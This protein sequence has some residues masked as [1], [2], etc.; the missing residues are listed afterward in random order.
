MYLGDD[1]GLLPNACSDIATIL[2]NTNTKAIIWNKPDYN[3][4][5]NK[6]TPNELNI[7]LNYDLIEMDSKILL[8]AVANG[9]TSYGRL[10]VIYSGFVSVDKI[11]QIKNKTGHFFHSITPDVYSGIVLAEILPNYLYSF[12]PFSINGGS[13]HSTG[14]AT[15]TNDD[16]GK[17]FFSE[18]RL[19]INAQIPIIR[20][21]IQTHVAEAFLKAQKVNLLQQYKLNFQRV[22][23]NI[24]NEL[25]HLSD[26][27]RS[28][29]LH[30][31]MGMNIDTSLRKKIENELQNENIEQRSFVNSPQSENK[32]INIESGHLSLNAA[33]FSIQNSYDACIFIGNLLGQYKMPEVTLKANTLSYAFSIVRR[34]MAIYL[35]KY[36]LPF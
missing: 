16:R 4:P 10:P 13:G 18:S 29:G 8:K 15:M 3:W 28:T 5:T 25:K 20:G 12:R 19:E 33:L 9:R 21:S 11:L 30:V 23:K 1:D 14:Q 24:F 36:L 7:E 34:K 26:P 17:L 35:K 6:I 32:I 31:L 27:I 2:M 22:H